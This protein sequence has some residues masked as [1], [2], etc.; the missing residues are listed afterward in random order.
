MVLH[1]GSWHTAE[2]SV[3]QYQLA[4]KAKKEE[5]HFAILF[6]ETATLEKVLFVGR[7]AQ[8]TGGT[9]VHIVKNRNLTAEVLGISRKRNVKKR[10][11]KAIVRNLELSGTHIAEKTS[12]TLHVVFAHPIV[13]KG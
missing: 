3:K 5:E 8:M 1:V 10:R 11:V 9:T 12:T 13:Q 4:E 6:V 7:N 2:G